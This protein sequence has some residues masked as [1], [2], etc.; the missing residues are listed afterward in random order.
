[1]QIRRSLI[2]VVLPVSLDYLESRLEGHF[3]V[4]NAVAIAIQDNSS[5]AL[6]QLFEDLLMLP[7]ELLQEI[8]AAKSQR[9]TENKRTT[10]WVPSTEAST[11]GR[12]RFRIT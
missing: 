10:A 2:N 6:K 4:V 1:M 3:Q 12:P 9:E 5:A 8:Q 7:R 11:W